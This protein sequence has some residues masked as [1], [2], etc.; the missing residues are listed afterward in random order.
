MSISAKFSLLAILA[1]VA[2]TRVH[3]QQVNRETP[4]LRFGPAGKFKIIQFTDTHFQF[5]SIRSDSVKLFIRE[6]VEKERP[7]LVVFTGDVVCSPKA[8]TKEGWLSLMQP[9]VETRTPWAIVFGNHDAQYDMTRQ[10]I[11]TLLATIPYNLSIPG[12]SEL[13]G[14]GN[15]ALEIKSKDGRSNAAIA[16]LFDSHEWPFDRRPYR[17]NEHSVYGEY[18]WIRMDQIQWYRH[19]S[20]AFTHANHDKALPSIA[21]FHIPLP[22]FREIIGSPTTVGF[23]GETVCSPTV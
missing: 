14:C 11:M 23:Q 7:D 15:Y 16:Y 13:T 12:P 3:G 9:L 21:F 1:L 17:P 5:N 6:I 22:E 2:M 10:Q 19:T 4:A 18:D 8:T 20:Q